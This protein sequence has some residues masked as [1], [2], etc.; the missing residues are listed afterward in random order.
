MSG[1]AEAAQQ[2]IERRGEVSEAHRLAEDAAESPR[3]RQRADQ[4][5]SGAPP[6]G[7]AKLEPVELQLGAG[8]MVELDRRQGAGAAAAAWRT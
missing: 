8:G 3:V 4:D 2:L 5:V 6:G 7:L 1:A